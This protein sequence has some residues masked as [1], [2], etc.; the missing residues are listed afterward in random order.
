MK[1]KIPR[2]ESSVVAEEEADALGDN[3]PIVA[4]PIG[5]QSAMPVGAAQNRMKYIY[6]KGLYKRAVVYHTSTVGDDRTDPY[7]WGIVV[8]VNPMAAWP[9]KVN[10]VDGNV[11][12]SN[13]DDLEP[14]YRGCSHND[15]K[16]MLNGR[17]LLN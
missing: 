8:E 6:G 7:L 12:W 17:K 9:L 16:D 4:R 3:R 5:A 13:G 14:V 2:P 15:L 1:V 11:K 10:W